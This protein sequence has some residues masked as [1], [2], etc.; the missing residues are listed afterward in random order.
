MT[1]LASDVSQSISAFSSDIQQRIAPR[2]R[3]NVHQAERWASGIVGGLLATYGLKRA[4]PGGLLLAALGGSLVWRGVTGHCLTYQALGID[5]AHRGR[6]RPEH[7][8]D[9][10]I[11]VEESMTI[12]RSPWDL[13]QFW[14]DLSNL[15]R[16]MQHLKEVRV[17]DGNRSHWVAR[18]PAGMSVEWDATIINEEENALIAWRSA[19]GAD[20]DNTGSVRFVPGPEGRG[21]EVKITLEYIPPAGQVGS[22][23]AKLF[24]EAPEQQ[25]REDLRRFKQLMEAGEIPTVQGQPRGTCS[26][27]GS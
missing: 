21:T 20:V 15:P 12:N 9:H 10:G 14:R 3:Q 2:S 6:S 1:S 13:Y 8:F 16:F 26:W 11:H 19:D 5:T 23:I 25:I 22:L 24:G 7:F 17:L 27:F 18:G 4:T